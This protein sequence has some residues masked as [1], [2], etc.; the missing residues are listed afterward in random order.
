[1]HAKGDGRVNGMGI[2]VSEEISKE[3]IRAERWEGQI[4][5]LW[6]VINGQMVLIMSIYEP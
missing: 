5:L 6:F 4:V 1:M 3:V 2:I